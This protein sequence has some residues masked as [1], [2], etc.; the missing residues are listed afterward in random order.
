VR[1][2]EVSISGGPQI[3]SFANIVP[4]M[5]KVLR[6]NTD[7]ELYNLLVVRHQGSEKSVAFISE[8]KSNRVCK[9]ML[10]ILTHIPKFIASKLGKIVI[11][12]V[13]AVRLLTLH[14]LKVINC[15]PFSFSEKHYL[16][17]QAFL[18]S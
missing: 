17:L 7:K 9:V 5:D 2:D 18:Q 12:M 14:D 1:D 10:D 6:L 11:F 13:T 4:R 3:H 16:M 8:C 15:S